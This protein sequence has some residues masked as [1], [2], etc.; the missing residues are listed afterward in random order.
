MK[1][2]TSG[3]KVSIPFILIAVMYVSI[4]VVLTPIISITPSVESK[5]FIIVIR[6]GL[7]FKQGDKLPYTG[8]IQDTLENKIIAYNVVNGLKHGEFLI[9]T[10]E[11]KSSVYG[12]VEKNKNIGTWKYFYD[13]GRLESTG[14]FRDDKPYGKWTWYYKS[15]KVKSEGNYISGKAEG[16]WIK[17]DERGNLNLII[18]YSRG[19]IVSE[20]KFNLPKSV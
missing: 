10:L 4:I 5:V 19:E 12:F 18:F 20:V 16:R 6:D 11:G 8:H 14:D 15:G 1:D 13:D 9:T 2:A 3:Y 17:Y 7:I